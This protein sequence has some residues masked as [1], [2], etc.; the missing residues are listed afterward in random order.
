M[1]WWVAY[2]CTVVVAAVVFRRFSKK[3]ETPEDPPGYTEEQS[4]ILDVVLACVWPI[5]ILVVIAMMAVAQ[6]HK[7]RLG[8][9]DD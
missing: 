6:W 7:W 1:S 8:V 2:C 5:T 3:V 9:R 4:R